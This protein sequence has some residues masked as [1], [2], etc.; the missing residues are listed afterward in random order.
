MP[1]KARTELTIKTMV[2]TTSSFPGPG[3]DKRAAAPQIGET[4][5]P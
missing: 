5:D 1:D 2:T 3:R 4:N